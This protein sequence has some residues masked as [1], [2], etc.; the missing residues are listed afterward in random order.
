MSRLPVPAFNL[1]QV[2]YQRVAPE[3]GG[4][5]ITGL[6]YRP[7]GT[8]QYLVSWGVAHEGSETQHWEAELTED[9]AF[10]GVA[11]EAE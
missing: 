9:K 2:V 7:G 6:L 4:G 8:I 10:E 3:D 5:M 1:G 11:R